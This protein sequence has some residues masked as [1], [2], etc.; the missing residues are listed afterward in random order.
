ML[1]LDEIPIFRG[2]LALS[3]LEHDFAC[4]AGERDSF[5]LRGERLVS[6]ARLIDGQRTVD[7]ILSLR[8]EQDTEVQALALLDQLASEQLIIP[9]HERYQQGQ[10]AFWQAVQG[11]DYAAEPALPLRMAVSCVGAD[12]ALPAVLRALR[13]EGIEPAPDAGHALVVS[14]DYL[15]IAGALS[16]RPAADARWLLCKPTGVSLW[17]GPL[18]GGSAGPCLECL[19]HWLR[20]NRPLHTVA[21]RAGASGEGAPLPRAATAASLEMASNLAALAA[22]R[23]LRSRTGDDVLHDQLLE[24]DLATFQL[25]SHTVV[26]RP[27]CAGCGDPG[28][29]ARS[30]WQPLRLGAPAKQLCED[31]GFRTAT[32]RETYQRHQHLVSRICG[33]VTHVLPMP[34]RDTP[35]RSVYTSAYRVT[36][37]QSRPHERQLRRYCAGKGRT[38]EQAQTSALCEALERYSGVYQGDEATRRGSLRQL[39]ACAV[40]PDA[41]QHFSAAQRQARRAQ[42]VTLEAHR[43][44]GG[45]VDEALELDWTPA[46][47]L[48]HERQRLVPL[49][50]CFSDTPPGPELAFCRYNANGAAA[51]NCLEEAILHGLFE[52]IERDAVAIWWYNCLP[53][54]ELPLEVLGDPYFTAL[55]TDYAR[56]GWR[57]WALDLTHDLGVPVC[58]ALA[59]DERQDRFCIGFGCHGSLALAAQRAFTELNQLFAPS[60]ARRAPWDLDALP[61]RDFLFPRASA[62]RCQPRPALCAR[63]DLGADV[64]ACVDALREAGLEVLVVNKT[65]PD[66]GLSVAHVMVP[67]LRHFWPR[68]G[69]G[70]L[71]TVPAA[72]GWLPE[73]LAEP[74]LNPVALFL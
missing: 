43:W 35:Q 32:P 17:I 19:C 38:P 8:A 53:R 24:L 33:A 41:L 9:R 49:A 45:E 40:H 21:L 2:D 51:G 54:P 70:R 6:L 34:E 15:Q 25:T 42:A 47:S 50:Y 72:L 69:P 3:V 48:T 18:L 1:R 60:S 58:V 62:S 23:F 5:A 13:Q 65:R 71:Y 31:G 22:A 7:E 4:L 14:D 26:R 39:G 66:V 11:A 20:I 29:M 16:H 46:W 10:S 67:G 44:V 63:P 27:Q 52:L 36:P 55:R 56:L 30:A 73:P 37:W 28:L 57:L 74:Q 61:A 59:Q 68:F 64:R 12:G